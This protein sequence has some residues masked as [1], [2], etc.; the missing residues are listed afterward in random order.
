MAA[1]TLL[2]FANFDQPKLRGAVLNTLVKNVPLMD[3]IKWD[4]TKNLTQVVTYISGLPTPAFRSLNEQGTEVKASFAQVQET[5]KILEVDIVID[6]VLL[7]LNSI[8]NVEAANADATIKSIGYF[9]NQML[10]QGNDD[11]DPEQPRGIDR[12]LRHDDR[13]AGQTVDAGNGTDTPLALTRAAGT[14]A[15]RYS[16]LD[17]LDDVIAR[18]GG[19]NFG[20]DPGLTFLCNVQNEQA[21]WSIVRRLKLLDTTKDQFDRTLT[22]FRGIPF[23]DVGFTPAAAVTGSFDAA[24]SQTNQ[25]IGNDSG[26]HAAATDPNGDAD[27][28]GALAYVT[29]STSLYCVRFDM[30]YFMGLQVAPLRVKNFGENVEIPSESKINVRWVFGFGAL[31]KRS[32]GRIIGLD[33]S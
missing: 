14:D 5:L 10:I 22:A 29:E 11:S 15:N 13:F 24:G 19:V 3:R 23:V 6:P 21:N 4:N 8:Q 1:I 26:S 9:V 7:M 32:L 25:I 28:A 30:D 27:K 33:F 17:A 2:E 16:Y 31:Q 12:R 18:M 20:G